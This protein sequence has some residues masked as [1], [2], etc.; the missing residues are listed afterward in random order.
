MDEEKLIRLSKQGYVEAFNQLVE[1]YQAQVYNLAMRMLGDAAA[2]EDIAQE[3]F[4]SAYR[5]LKSFH[6]G[7]FRAWLLRIG[8]NASRDYLR[9]ARLRRNVSLEELDGNPGFVLPSTS[10]SPEA[11]ALRQELSGT[12]LKGLAGL[13]EEQRLAVVLV[14]LHGLSYEE[15]AQVMRIP[16]GTVKSR[17][18]RGRMAMRDFLLTQ[19]ELLPGNLRLGK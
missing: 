17:L 8:A 12:I 15:V 5:H 3:T 6:S 19:R 13:P 7:S 16:I 2:A 10:E 1:A 11:F 9:S 18:S 14:D 4:F